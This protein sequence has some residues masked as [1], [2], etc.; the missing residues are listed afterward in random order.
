MAKKSEVPVENVEST[1]L[2]EEV[3]VETN[4]EVEMV[5]KEPLVVL[6]MDEDIEQPTYA[7]EEASGMDV[8]AEKVFKTLFQ[9]EKD[10]YVKQ[11]FI[12]HGSIFLS[13]GDRLVFGTGLQVTNMNPNYEI[14]V[15]PKS[16]QSLKKGFT[17]VN[18]PGTIDSDY[19]GEI[20][21]IV[22]NHTQH[23][24]E[25]VKGEKIAQI[26]LVQKGPKILNFTRTVSPIIE[27]TERNSEGFGSTGIV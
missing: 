6:N 15:L 1:G 11:M 20:G 26:Q 24:I 5:D 8:K 4:Q 3:K 13:P 23:P 9:E 21:V 27:E 17:I 12:K 18:A 16:G 14:K 2:K 7:T 19:R 22:A 25:I 10:T